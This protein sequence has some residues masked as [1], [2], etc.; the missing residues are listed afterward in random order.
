MNISIENRKPPRMRSV[1]QAV[2][3]LEADGITEIGAYRLRL[4]ARRMGIWSSFRDYNNVVSEPLLYQRKFL[5]H[6]IDQESFLTAV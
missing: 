5:T 4:W 6:H 2:K 3:Q 1:P